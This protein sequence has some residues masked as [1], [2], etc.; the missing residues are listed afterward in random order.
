MNALKFKVGNKSTYFMYPEK[1]ISQKNPKIL[2][3]LTS[4]LRN[5]SALVLKIKYEY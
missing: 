3:K 1:L 4:S 5:K 2:E